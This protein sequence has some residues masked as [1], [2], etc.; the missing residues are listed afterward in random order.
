MVAK[1]KIEERERERE[2]KRESKIVCVCVCVWCEQA[3]KNLCEI[4][5]IFIVNSDQLMQFKVEL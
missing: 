5:H 3:L 2:R 4:Y 1:K